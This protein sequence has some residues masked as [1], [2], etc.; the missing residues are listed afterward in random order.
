MATPTSPQTELEA[1]NM[2]L[3]AIFE[4]P[5]NSLD[6]PGVSDAGIA[7]S[8]LDETAREVLMRG[9]DFNTEEGVVLTPDSVTSK[10]PLPNNTVRAD[11]SSSESIRATQRGGFLYD[12]TNKRYTFTAPIK[13]DLVYLF[14]WSEL[15]E[16]AK[17]YIAVRA[18]RKFQEATLGAEQGRYKKA[19]EMDAKVLLEDAEGDTADYNILS[20]SYSVMDILAPEFRN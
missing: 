19:D 14:D 12:K 8:I 15:P 6:V 3:K 17:W 5:V 11:S 9:W 7:K 1:V 16:P 13:C 18:A 4:A 2:M 20:D 10:V